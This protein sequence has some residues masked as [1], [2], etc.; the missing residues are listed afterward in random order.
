MPAEEETTTVAVPV[1]TPDSSIMKTQAN[2]EKSSMV[3][4]TEK[5]F[6]K[7]PQITENKETHQEEKKHED[8]QEASKSEEEENKE[9]M[10]QNISKI[11]NATI[12]PVETK[13]KAEATGKTEGIGL[14]KRR[15]PDKKENKEE[16]VSPPKKVK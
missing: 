13:G 3:D 1:T 15:T 6:G 5:T 12:D 9:N 16:D 8:M 4:P 14:R 2:A 10:Q 7:C 11:E